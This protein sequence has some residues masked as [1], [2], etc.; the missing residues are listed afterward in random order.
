MGAS[1]VATDTHLNGEAADLPP[2]AAGLPNLTDEEVA[3]RDQERER[4][5]TLSTL[6]AMT[7]D[8]YGRKRIVLSEELETPVTWLDKAYGEQRARHNKQGS[9]KAP[10]KFLEAVHPWEEPVDGAELVTD[11]AAMVGRHVVLQGNAALV[12]A[13]WLIHAHAHDCFSIS[14]I[15]AIQSPEKRCGKTTLLGLLQHLMPKALTAS[16]MTMAAIYRVIEERRVSLVIDEADTF[17]NADNPELV[18]ILNSG[19]T[20][21]SAFVVRTV[22]D[23]HETTTFSTWCAKVIALIGKLPPTLQDRSIVTALERKRPEQRVERRRADRA[24]D[25]LEL[26]RKAARWAADHQCEL[27]EC[28]PVPPDTLDDRAADNWRPLLAIA[29]VIGGN[30]PQHARKAARALSGGRDADDESPGVLLLRD[31]RE[32]MDERVAYLSPSSLLEKL[33]A[34][35]EAPW[36]DW[37][38]GKPITARGVSNLLRPY[39]IGSELKRE[40]GTPGR[41]YYREAFLNAWGRYL[42]QP[43]KTSVTSVTALPAQ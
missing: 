12:I 30:W 41:R 36:K 28:D 15:L 20:R 1:M 6:G 22:G 33:H 42:L 37:C 35:E 14:P 23:N 5:A 39:G 3:Q 34:L 43:S 9:D 31:I 26:C 10:A 40:A 13:L 27:E 17:I 25:L 24:L 21:T 7:P 29:E 11:L 4:Q 32:V 8:E 16:N 19:H 18:G 38:H 2:R